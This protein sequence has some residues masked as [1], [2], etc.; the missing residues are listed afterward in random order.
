MRL[1]S[2]LKRI[3]YDELQFHLYSDWPPRDGG[4]L[5]T[6]EIS[7][8][9]H[10]SHRPHIRLCRSHLGAHPTH[11]EPTK[12]LAGQHL[13][14]GQLF[15]TSLWFSDI[16]FF[17]LV[18]HWGDSSGDGSRDPRDCQ[19]DPVCPP[20][21]HQSQVGSPIYNFTLKVM[22]VCISVWFLAVWRLGAVLRFK[23]ACCRFQYW[24]CLTPAMY[25]AILGFLFGLVNSSRLSSCSPCLCSSGCGLWAAV[26]WPAL[27]G[28][29]MQRD[30][31]ELHLHGWQVGL[32]S[33]WVSE[34]VKVWKVKLHISGKFCAIIH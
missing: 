8:H 16:L 13:C 27:V 23:S 30:F 17:F 19:R 9:P 6:V 26:Q 4:P 15:Y 28:Q 29:H 34:C 18:L 10:R 24:S 20:E 1:K 5:V 12:R 33:G 3:L 7:G 31:S 32:F 22:F 2:L 14:E 21:Q 11:P 25:V